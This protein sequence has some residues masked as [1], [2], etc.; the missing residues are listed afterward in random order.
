VPVYFRGK[1]RKLYREPPER[2]EPV[3]ATA[4]DEQ[5]EEVGTSGDTWG[6]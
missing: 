2:E 4:A 5:A 6:P 1:G 3:D